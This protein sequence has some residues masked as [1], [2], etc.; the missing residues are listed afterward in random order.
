MNHNPVLGQV[1]AL[2]QSNIIITGRVVTST[3]GAI[4]TQDSRGG[5]VTVTKTGATAGRYTF[6]LIAA[7]DVALTSMTLLYV[8]AILLGPNTAAFTDAK[9]RDPTLRA[10]DVCRNNN[11]GTFELQFT[12]ADTGADAEVEDGAAF[13]FMIV[14]GNSSAVG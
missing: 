3:V 7:Q 13:L 1:K 11:D 10:D 6:Q 14:L 9:G 4:S 5:G 2:G 8:N 12:D